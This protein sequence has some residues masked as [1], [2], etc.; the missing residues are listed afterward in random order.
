M[1]L[2]LKKNN[3]NC[4]RFF[5]LVLNLCLLA[6]AGRSQRA[7]EIRRYKIPDSIHL[8]GVAV[9]DSFFYVISNTSVYKY[10]KEDGRLTAFFD[11]KKDGI[12]KHLNGG[13]VRNG[14]LYCAHSNFPDTPMAS[15]IEIFDVR[16]MRHI[17]NH[18][19]GLFGGSVTWIDEKDGRWWAAF[20]NYNGRRSSEGRD[21]RWTQLAAFTK[22]WEKLSSWIYPANVLEA[23]APYSNSGGAWSRNGELYVTGHDRKEIYVLDIPTSGFTLKHIRT[24]PIV[25]SGQGIALDRS[26]KTGETLYAVNREDNSII[27]ERL[28]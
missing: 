10:R 14:K 15:S 8:Q 13:I 19:F 6:L 3:T 1:R 24:I 2:F 4:F 27:V 9:D 22:K 23:F 21:N 18:S 28:Y 20:A 26:V 16:T 5:F 25:N 17:G 12:M 11:G 7:E